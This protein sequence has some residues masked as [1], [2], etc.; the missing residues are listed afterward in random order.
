MK[1]YITAERRNQR[2]VAK[3][4]GCFFFAQKPKKC[5]KFLKIFEKSCP[6][7]PEW[8]L[9]KAKK[10]FIIKAQKEKIEPRRRI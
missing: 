9:C 7:V 2:A 1:N 10:F 4:S 3:K 8:V 6:K 5:E